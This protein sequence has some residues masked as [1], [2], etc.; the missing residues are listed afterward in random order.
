[1]NVQI[2]EII[3][4]IRQQ[5]AFIDNDID[6]LYGLLDVSNPISVLTTNPTPEPV[7][8]NPPATAGAPQD[9][10]TADAWGVTTLA[11]T[12]TVLFQGG[13]ANCEAWANANCPN[14]FSLRPVLRPVLAVAST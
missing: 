1:M 11:D 9:T 3:T 6:E 13:Q 8:D 10:P 4:K 5:L 2:S 14:G 12:D 7:A